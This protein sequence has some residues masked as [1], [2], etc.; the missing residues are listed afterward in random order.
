MRCNL[1]RKQALW[2][3]ARTKYV[4]SGFSRSDN[5]WL[6][7]E[8]E[9]FGSNSLCAEKVDYKYYAGQTLSSINEESGFSTIM[10]KVTWENI[11][12]ERRYLGVHKECDNGSREE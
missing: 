4:M 2:V 8:M 3:K 10:G 11:S 9:T 5:N 12:Y 1:S 7:Y 6:K